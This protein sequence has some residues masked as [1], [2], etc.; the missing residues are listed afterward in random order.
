VA[1]CR[2]PAGG[3]FLSGRISRFFP[4]QVSVVLVVADR[5]VGRQNS[6]ATRRNTVSTALLDDFDL[7]IRLA[8]PET[9]SL[10]VAA[11]SSRTSSPWTEFNCCTD[12]CC[13]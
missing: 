1:V 4:A 10:P 6:P 5:K 3:F 12:A 9:H 11:V 7:D 8:A 13:G 2:C